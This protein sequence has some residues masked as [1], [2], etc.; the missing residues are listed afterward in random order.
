MLVMLLR[1]GRRE[2]LMRGEG[3]A[4]V[5]NGWLN[6]I[7]DAPGDHGLRVVCCRGELVCDRRLQLHSALSC[8]HGARLLLLLLLLSVVKAKV[9][10]PC[11][12]ILALSVAG[13]LTRHQ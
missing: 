9:P 8:M 2:R 5:G 11:R 4:G 1:R 10:L 3:R 13:R 6:G 12:C 7:F